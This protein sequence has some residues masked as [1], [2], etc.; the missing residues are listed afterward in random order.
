MDIHVNLHHLIEIRV[1][2][3]VFVC[4]RLLFLLW[5]DPVRNRACP[6]ILLWGT[7]TNATAP[8]ALAAREAAEAWSQWFASH[9]WGEA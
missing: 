2:V 4:L 6:C 7:P 9:L 5:C 1:R 3:S 8:A